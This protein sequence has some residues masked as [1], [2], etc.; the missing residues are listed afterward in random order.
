MVGKRGEGLGHGAAIISQHRQPEL[1]PGATECCWTGRL[2]VPLIQ[3]PAC[4]VA[5]QHSAGSS[6]EQ[7]AAQHSGLT[8]LAVR[9]KEFLGMQVH[10]TR[11]FLL[12]V[13]I[14]LM[15]LVCPAPVQSQEQ[16]DK[17]RV[18]FIG[19]SLTSA[20]KLPHMFRSIAEHHGK[21]VL[22]SSHAP[23]GARLAQHA[24]NKRVA[25]LLQQGSWDAVVLQEQSQYPAFSEQQV[26]RDV[27]PHAKKLVEMAR[28]ANPQVMVV[29]YQTM[30]RQQHGDPD[31][32]DKVSEE[33]RS[34]AGMQ[35][36]IN[37]S[38][39]KMAQDNRA[40]LAPIGGAWANFTAAVSGHGDLCR[41]CASEC[42]RHLPGC[43]YVLCHYF[44][45][46]R[47]G[48]AGPE[49]RQ[50]RRRPIYT[51]HCRFAASALTGR[52]QPEHALAVQSR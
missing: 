50:P 16:A 3:D 12:L 27:E 18:L 39:A 33:L 38:Y 19:N 52:Y 4:S 25:D 45:W 51:N 35:K 49:W 9:K 11:S 7:A 17:F 24:E 10:G 22:C 43:L 21:A 28:A 31:N 41:P 14:G 42:N 13:I 6:T 34:Y 26:A 44:R 20:N 48:V 37:R 40:K 8:R 32:A 46:F 5:G 47:S 23:G 36:R 1:I 15:V 29:F 2:S 30:A